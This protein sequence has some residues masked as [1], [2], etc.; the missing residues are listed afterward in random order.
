M[1]HEDS[2]SC[3]YQQLLVPTL[4]QINPVHTTPSYFPKLHINIIHSI[5]IWS[6]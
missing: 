1:E 2:L 5:Y 6:F 3:S 4:T